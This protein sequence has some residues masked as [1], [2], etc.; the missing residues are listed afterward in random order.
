LTNGAGFSSAPSSI[1]TSGGFNAGD[2]W[3]DDAKYD[4]SDCG[5]KAED[6]IPMPSQAKVDRFEKACILLDTEMQKI[7]RQII[8]PYEAMQEEAEEID[9]NLRQAKIA[10]HGLT[11]ADEIKS[12]K[13]EVEKWKKKADELE[14]AATITPKQLDEAFA[15]RDEIYN[16]YRDAVAAFCSN[17]PTRKQ[18]D[19]V[20]NYILMPFINH[21][22]GKL[23]NPEG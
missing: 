2:L 14:E 5:V 20:P 6:K 22:R 23:L 3:G 18:L 9:F 17:K 19:G 8:K 7:N 16:H 12:N 21:I 10:R 1:T 11:D 4:F 13:A 15:Q